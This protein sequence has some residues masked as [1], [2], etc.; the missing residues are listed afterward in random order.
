[1]MM[2]REDSNINDIV[3][4][5]TSTTEPYMVFSTETTEEVD[6]VLFLISNF[7]FTPR[8]VFCIGGFLR[9]Q[10]NYFF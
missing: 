3:L 7:L 1:M 4:R 9:W 2:Y 8:N 10:S 5:I 6:I